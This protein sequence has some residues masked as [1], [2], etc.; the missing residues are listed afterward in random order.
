MEYLSQGQNIFCPQTLT[1]SP[2]NGVRMLMV[3][4]MYLYFMGE[5]SVY[6]WVSWVKYLGGRSGEMFVPLHLWLS[7]AWYSTEG[8]VRTLGERAPHS[9]CSPFLQDGYDLVSSREEQGCLR[10]T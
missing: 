3:L 6:F 10:L 7:N 4:G 5:S 9:D 8:A 2:S 1:L